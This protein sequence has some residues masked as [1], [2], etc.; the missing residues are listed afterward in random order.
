MPQKRQTPSSKA[1]TPAF[2]SDFVCIVRHCIGHRSRCTGFQCKTF[3]KMPLEDRPAHQSCREQTG[4][5]INRQERLSGGENNSR[6]DVFKSVHNVKA[7][8]AGSDLWQIEFT[9]GVG[10]S[11]LEILENE[12]N[13]PRFQR[14][15]KK[16]GGVCVFGGG[17]A[18]LGPGVGFGV[19]GCG[20]G[21]L[22]WGDV[23]AA[24][25]CAEEEFER[26]RR[27]ERRT[28]PCV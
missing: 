4:R 23:S 22:R 18:A 7:G 6:S 11:I 3:P 12:E 14:S 24:R 21:L 2:K 13:A 28:A 5:D 1:T 17:D 15:G 9:D 25:A 16:A 8:R 10:W 19:A 20:H 27:R 26:C